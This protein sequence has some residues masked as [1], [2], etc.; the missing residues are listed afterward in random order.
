MVANNAVN[1]ETAGLV[2]YD[3]AGTFT[4]VTTTIHDVLLGAASNGI[5]NIAPSATAGI[6]LVS[7]GASADPSFTTAVVQGGGTGQ[8]TFPNH[9]LLI[10]ATTSPIGSLSPG[11]NG[12]LVQ[13]VNASSDPAYTTAGYPS[14]AG[15]S[16]N[17]I[18]SNGTNFVS[19]VLPTTTLTNHAVALGTGTA[20]LSAT[21][22]GS[23]GQV[24]QSGGSS[25]DPTYSTATF[26]STASSTGTILRAN[27]TNWVATTATYPTTTT[28]NQ[29]LYSSSASVIGGITTAN[30]SI[31]STDGSGVPTLGTSLSN[32]YTFTS[33]TAGAT[34]TV[35][36]S[37]TDN[38]N[39]ASNANFTA[40]VG[41]TSGGDAYSVYAVGSTRSYSVGVDT[42]DSQ[43]LKIN[44]TNAATVGPSTGTTLMTLSSTGVRTLPLNPAV[45][46][47]VHNGG[48][49]ITNVT[50]DGTVYTIIFDS[51]ALD[52]GTNFN[53][54]TGAFTAPVAG[55][56][57]V[58]ANVT[59]TGLGVA[60]TSALLSISCNGAITRNQFN[61]IA[62]AVG[63]ILTCSLSIIYPLPVSTTI[64]ATIQV[65]GS[66]KTVGV[67]FDNFAYF[68]NLSVS[69]LG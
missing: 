4:G 20:N 61:P 46:A 6:P 3:G 32:N 27:G 22:T 15:T 63:G 49:N 55:N 9:S 11:N 5:T 17:V 12:S 23:A 47:Y 43:K 40:S 68:T 19:Q 8:Q 16:G 25:A 26:P 59:L 48:A 29:I 67:S 28:V 41:G 37:N 35:T 62:S 56:Y 60:H 31:V 53:T 66:T 64:S 42:S 45:F 2:K 1:I 50:G 18:T 54:T 13:C 30:N 10:G 58:I 44:T 36:S 39:T 57:L 52:A 38:T 14:T 33:A 69:L 51:T 21:A 24:L 34:R 65:S 7:N